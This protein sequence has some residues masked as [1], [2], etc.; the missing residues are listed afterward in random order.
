MNKRLSLIIIF[1]GLIILL[2]CRNS[3]PVSQPTVTENTDTITKKLIEDEKPPMEDS[4]VLAS[5]YDDDNTDE[6][7]YWNHVITGQKASDQIVGKFDGRHIDTVYIE[8]IFIDDI[9]DDD[10]C[11]YY[12]CSKSG[13]LPKVRLDGC[14]FMKPLI[15]AEGDLD[16]NGTDDI[17]YL[18]TGVNGQW[19][20][21]L[22]LTFRKGEWMLLFDIEDCLS[23]CQPFRTSGEKIVEPYKKGKVIVKYMECNIYEIKDTILTINPKK[24]V[25]EDE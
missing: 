23:T 4:V 25:Y 9:E 2:S 20:F 19:R 15:Y 1:C 10:H 16:G 22:I 21:Y 3:A 13:R 7:M 14:M 8:R 17:G 5:I 18:N 6:Y 11:R 24:I 12:L